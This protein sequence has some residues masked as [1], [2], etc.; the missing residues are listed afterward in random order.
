MFAGTYRWFFVTPG[1]LAISDSI[2]YLPRFISITTNKALEKKVGWS[3]FRSVTIFFWKEK[4]A[5]IKFVKFPSVTGLYV[6]TELYGVYTLKKEMTWGFCCCF[7]GPNNRGH[8]SSVGTLPQQVGWSVNKFSSKPWKKSKNYVHFARDNYF[9][10]VNNWIECIIFD[11]LEIYGTLSVSKT[12]FLPSQAVW[13]SSRREQQWYQPQV[14][15]FSQS[16]LKNIYIKKIECLWWSLETVEN[17]YMM[18]QRSLSVAEWNPKIF[19]NCFQ[20]GRDRIVL[21]F[22]ITLL[23]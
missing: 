4:N 15:I 10:D 6:L 17:F 20:L 19:L 7:V 2:M 13:V 11:L 3:L 5:E 16:V 23:V 14:G 21:L 22:K 9:S 12:P 8:N 1:Y 18:K